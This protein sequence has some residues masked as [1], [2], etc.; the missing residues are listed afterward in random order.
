[1][2]VNGK[3][4]SAETIPGRG[5]KENGGGVNSSDISGYNLIL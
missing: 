4:I 1:M 2:G 5:W 3:M